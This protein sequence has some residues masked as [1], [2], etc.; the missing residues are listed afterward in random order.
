MHKSLWKKLHCI[1]IKEPSQPELKCCFHN[2]ERETKQSKLEKLLGVVWAVHIVFLF[3]LYCFTTGN[4]CGAFTYENIAVGSLGS[5]SFSSCHKWSHGKIILDGNFV[6]FPPFFFLF[7]FLGDNLLEKR[8]DKIEIYGIVQCLENT[9]TFSEILFAQQKDKGRALIE[10][11]HLPSF[12]LVPYYYLHR[13]L[14]KNEHNRILFNTLPCLRQ[15]CGFLGPL[16][17]KDWIHAFLPQMCNLNWM[18]TLDLNSV[19]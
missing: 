12:P 4:Q 18:K 2:T 14:K 7:I 3:L 19:L 9:H 16:S 13:F 5:I 17:N 6:F 1:V 10:W 11:K 8:A 15:I